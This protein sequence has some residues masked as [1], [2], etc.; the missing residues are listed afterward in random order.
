M[1][2]VGLREVATRSDENLLD[3][4]RV[5]DDDDPARTETH[6]HEVAVLA[7]ATLEKAEQSRLIRGDTAQKS[8]RG[9]GEVSC[10]QTE[11]LSCEVSEALARDASHRRERET[12]FYTIR[13]E[14]VH[15]PVVGEGGRERALNSRDFDL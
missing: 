9:R 13:G 11:A 6:R 7:R 5:A 12:R 14:E 2:Y 15:E 10:G 1:P 3:V 8:A 4:V